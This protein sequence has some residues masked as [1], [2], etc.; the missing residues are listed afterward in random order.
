MFLNCSN[1]RLINLKIRSA[2]GGNLR[3]QVPNEVAV[4]SVKG[5][6]LA[7]GANPNPL[8]AAID[9]PAV[10]IVPNSPIQQI[11]VKKTWVYDLPTEKGKVYEVAFV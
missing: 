7:S 3:L 11:E 1:S 8:F 9:M 4:Q 10:L 5:I 2:L 6:K